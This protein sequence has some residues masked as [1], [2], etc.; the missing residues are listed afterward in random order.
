M[1]LPN[2]ADLLKELR[3]VDAAI[4]V[5]LKEGGELDVVMAGLSHQLVRC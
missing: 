2:P 5:G 1:S 3:S 4:R